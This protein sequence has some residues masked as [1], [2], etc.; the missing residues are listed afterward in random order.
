MDNNSVYGWYVLNYMSGPNVSRPTIYFP[1]GVK[2]SGQLTMSAE[3]MILV[4]KMLQL[5]G[6]RAAHFNKQ[7]REKYPNV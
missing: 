5:E 2:N 3:E 4:G 1:E 6:E 7:V